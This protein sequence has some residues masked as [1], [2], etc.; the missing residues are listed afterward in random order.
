MVDRLATTDYTADFLRGWPNEGALETSVYP[1]ESS[2][3]LE[4]G[5]LVVLD[6]NGELVKTSSDN[7]FAAIVVR[8]NLDDKSVKESGRAIVLWGGY[9]VRTTKITAGLGTADPMTPVIA[10]SS[11]VFADA[12]GTT[13][14]TSTTDA[15][16][17]PLG[18][19]LESD[20]GGGSNPATAVIVVR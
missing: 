12:T 4:A 16:V 10:N 17:V 14:G 8:G 18:V 9:V 2:T 6:S 1:I 7:N 19:V 5:D 11:G 3:D 13:L 15:A 20:S